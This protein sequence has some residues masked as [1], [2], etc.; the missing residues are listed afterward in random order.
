MDTTDQQL[1]KETVSKLL[2]PK[3]GILAA[4]ESTGT[5]GKRLERVG[6]ENTMENRQKMRDLFLTAPGMEKY[7]SGVILYDETINQN[8]RDGT[9]FI[10]ILIENGVVPG[11][12][13]D[14][15][16]ST[17]PEFATEDV[18]E[19]LDGLR[20]RMNEYFGMGARFAKWRSAHPV[21]KDLP[22]EEMVGKNMEQMATYAAI[23]QA[24]DMVPIVEPEVLMNGEHGIERAARV[25]G[26]VLSRLFKELKEERVW[27]PGVILK[28]SMVLPGADADEQKSPEEVA[29]ATV[30]VLT[31][32][33]PKELGGVVFLSG[34]QSAEQAA[35]NLNAIAKREPLPWEISFSFSRALEHPALDVWGGKDENI[36]KAQKAFV[37]QLK[38][39]TLADQGKLLDTNNE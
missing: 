36:P 6:L 3:K 25:T 12:K 13:V 32:V 8:S 16:R 37:E 30:R 31:G 26:Q 10:Q 19:G 33:V 27:L 21:T 39:D 23:A 4:D 15:G 17:L 5:A 24:E 2:I 20:G 34:G 11:I 28:T 35:E 9:P 7:V 14:K 38:I 29:A 22:T 18:T 1:L